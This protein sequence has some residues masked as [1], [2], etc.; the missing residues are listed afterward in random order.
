MT[1]GVFRKIIREELRPEIDEFRQ[2]NL[3]IMVL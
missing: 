1:P 3:E 2:E